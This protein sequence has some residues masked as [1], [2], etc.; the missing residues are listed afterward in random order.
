MLTLSCTQMSGMCNH[1]C[2]TGPTIRRSCHASS[3]DTQI[4]RSDLVRLAFDLNAQCISLT[5]DRMATSTAPNG[6]SG[7]P[8]GN[9]TSCEQYM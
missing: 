2:A 5:C 8:A 7:S 1:A 9:K 4:Q 6:E 3:Y